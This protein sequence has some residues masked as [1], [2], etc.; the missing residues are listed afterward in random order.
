MKKKISLCGLQTFMAVP[1]E[2]KATGVNDN[3]GR[4]ASPV[5][6]TRDMYKRGK[7]NSYS[8]R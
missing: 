6:D 7:D 2:R 4:E 8:I 1:E 5:T 3:R